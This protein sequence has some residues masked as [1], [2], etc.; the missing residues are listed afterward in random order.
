MQR[1]ALKVRAAKDLMLTEYI[2]C[3]M[4][5]AHYELMENGRYFG[6]ISACKGAWAE[7]RTLEECRDQLQSV[8][9]DWI[10]LGLHLGDKLPVIDGL[11][12]NRTNR[13][14]PAHAQTRQ[15]S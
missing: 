4:R 3:A 13:K 8:L 1:P 14:R 11:N 15:A 7:G 5:H 6:A 9:E 12:L 10:L 2:R